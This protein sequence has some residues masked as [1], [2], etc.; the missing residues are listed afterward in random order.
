MK[1]DSLIS[2]RPQYANAI[3][4]GHKT[5]ELR[6]RIPRIEQ[7]ARLWIYSTLPEGAIIGSA[8]VEDVYRMKP[9]L[10]WKKFAKKTGVTRQTFDDYFVGVEHSIG[11]VLT[12]PMRIHPVNLSALRQIR[13][14]F[15]PP[16]VLNK[17]KPKIQK[18]LS[19]AR[20]M[21]A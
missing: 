18:R 16:Q 10:L 14:D 11:I 19:S 12:R 8:F 7:G 21:V 3:L 17:L 20:S 5:I 2:I 4:D 9:E 6:R 15:Q 13:S 1:T